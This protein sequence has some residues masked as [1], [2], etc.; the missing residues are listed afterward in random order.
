MEY[1]K[2]ASITGQEML[3][4]VTRRLFQLTGLVISASLSRFTIA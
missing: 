2:V 3:Q 1:L 4:V